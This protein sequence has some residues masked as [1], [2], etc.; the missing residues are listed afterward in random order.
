MNKHPGGIWNT[1]A[2]EEIFER[3][4]T[5]YLRE[6]VVDVYRDHL[7]RYLDFVARNVGKVVLMGGMKINMPK[8]RLTEELS[9][10]VR[11]GIRAELPLVPYITQRESQ[12]FLTI[13]KVDTATGYILGSSSVVLGH[14]QS[15]ATAL[16]NS[17]TGLTFDHTVLIDDT[18][19]ELK[20]QGLKV[21]DLYNPNC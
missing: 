12:D 19:E 16:W 15:E 17:S 9:Q 11:E 3:H 13:G 7:E 1:P 8:A 2:V 10:R 20:L 5:H 14:R 6:G 21:V 4:M 18:M